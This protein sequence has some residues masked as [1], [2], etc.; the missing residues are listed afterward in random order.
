M[1]QQAFNRRLHG[2]W[3]TSVIDFLLARSVLII[4]TGRK[5]ILQARAFIALWSINLVICILPLQV[6]FVFAYDRP[7]A[8]SLRCRYFHSISPI[9]AIFRSGSVSSQSA[10]YCRFPAFCFSIC[11]HQLSLS[12]GRH[13]HDRCNVSDFSYFSVD[14]LIFTAIPRSNNN[15]KYIGQKGRNVRADLVVALMTN[16]NRR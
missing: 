3:Y 1:Q 12:T 6:L 10:I 14:R 7:D 15:N 8:S 13:T 4:L 5:G 16:Q 9:T 11:L 2:H